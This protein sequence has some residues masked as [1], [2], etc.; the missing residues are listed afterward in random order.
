[1]SARTGEGW[2]VV[3]IATGDDETRYAA[4][5]AAEVPGGTVFEE[6]QIDAWYVQDGKRVLPLDPDARK[7]VGSKGMTLR[8]YHAR[9]HDTYGDKPPGSGYDKKGLVGGFGQREEKAREAAAPA[10]HTSAE[11]HSPADALVPVGAS[12]AVMAAA[13]T[14]VWLVRRRGTRP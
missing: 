2:Q 13:A 3:N 11:A 9:V 14:G 5:G 4:K 8:A 12:A 10:T 1:M 6:P 7:A